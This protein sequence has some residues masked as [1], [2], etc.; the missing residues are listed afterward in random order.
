[1]STGNIIKISNGVL[2]ETAKNEYTVFA[3]TITSNAGKKVVEHSTDGIVFGEP[4][5][6]SKQ[7]DAKIIVHFRPKAG[8]KGEG[9]G[10]DWLRRA[11]ISPA[12]AG[13][14]K[15]ETII[16]KY[17]SKA[18]HTP[19][20]I[21]RDI[22]SAGP[23]FSLNDGKDVQN[24]GPFLS[25]KAEYSKH[26]IPWRNKK[27]S[28]GAEIRDAS[29]NPV[30]EEY[31]VP[32]LSLFPA[33]VGTP[34]KATTYSNTKAVLSL[35]VDIEEDADSLEFDDNPNF[36]ITP[37]QVNVKG[38]GIK[39]LN[40]AVTIECK[41]E[42]AAD[43]LITIRSIKTAADGKKTTAIAGRINV[44]ANSQRK[45]KKIVLVAVKTSISNAYSSTGGQEA[46]FRKFMNQALVNPEVATDMLDVSALPDF[47]AKYVKGGQIGAYYSDD[48][49]T[50][51]VTRNSHKPA[52]FQAMEVFLSG[53][54]PAKYNGYFKA[55]Y[56]NDGGGFVDTS[57]IVQGLNGYSSGNNV[58][59]F[60]TKNDET[61]AHEFLHSLD[62]PHTFVNAEAA[63]QAKFTF[64]IKK[65]DNVMDYSHQ[66]NIQRTNLWHW[67]WKVAHAAAENE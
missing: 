55:F 11:D 21:Y 48:Y 34:A 12:V 52:S 36:V 35:I 3:E 27:N 56:L 54:L 5:I 58:V 39:R 4:I 45:K 65:T 26:T 14:V 32:W 9:Y 53:L 19:A 46:L 57:N 13:D 20:N 25:L 41:K 44:W 38:K 51:P 40:D 17:Y 15:Y 31:F 43:Q 66:A 28:S 47:A 61:A 8:W 42:F 59:L 37:K 16:G 33:T 18:P 6:P 30:K 10:F 62:L 49:S 60:P 23:D 22:N 50:S 1:M 29:N 63:P 67:Q 64:E 24:A 2:K 7:I